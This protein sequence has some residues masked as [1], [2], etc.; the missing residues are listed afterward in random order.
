MA[1]REEIARP[2][3]EEV[4]AGLDEIA[5]ARSG[6]TGMRLGWWQGLPVRVPAG[7]DGQDAWA[8]EI[9]EPGCPLSRT[10]P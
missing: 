9:G 2:G 10:Y 6:R 3:V 7:L 5:G 8:R 4:R 1:G